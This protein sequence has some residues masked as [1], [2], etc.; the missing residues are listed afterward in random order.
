MAINRKPRRSIWMYGLES[1]EPSD[2]QRRSY[3][4]ELAGRLGVAIDVPPIPRADGLRLRPP[5][6]RPP[7]SIAEF[8]F[9]DNY[10]RALHSYWG[11]RGPAIMG[12][13][14]NPPDVVA[15]P[16]NEGEMEAI[17]E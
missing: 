7:D 4:K 1:E 3:A 16:R 9:R 10:E 8:C 12:E 2:E 14:P 6:I 17:L 13:F 15:H 11:Y 5:R